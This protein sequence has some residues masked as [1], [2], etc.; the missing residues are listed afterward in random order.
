MTAIFLLSCSETE[1]ALLASA[2]HGALFGYAVKPKTE[3]AFK[4]AS[5]LHFTE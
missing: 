4:A 5:S 3:S 1:Y 2:T